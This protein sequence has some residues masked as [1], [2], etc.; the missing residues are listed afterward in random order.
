MVDVTTGT[1]FTQHTTNPVEVIVYGK[2]FKN[3][4]LKPSGA[5]CDIAP[6]ILQMMQVPQPMEMT[7]ISLIAG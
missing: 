5:L 7:G 6:T 2:K 4:K 1:P 3:F